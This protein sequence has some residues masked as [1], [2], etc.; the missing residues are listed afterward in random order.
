MTYAD[1]QRSGK[2]STLDGN[3]VLRP[4]ATKAAAL[5][6]AK[7]LPGL[8]RVATPAGNLVRYVDNRGAQ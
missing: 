6:A 3:L 5:K 1:T 8:V 2:Y 4:H 7:T